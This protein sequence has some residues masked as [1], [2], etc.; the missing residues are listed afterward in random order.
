MAGPGQVQTRVNSLGLG[1]WLPA[2]RQQFMYQAGSLG[3][4]PRQ[5]IFEMSERVVAIEPGAL[6]QI[7]DGGRALGIQRARAL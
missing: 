6:N 7:H 2:M 1:L 3:W 5:H 4:Q